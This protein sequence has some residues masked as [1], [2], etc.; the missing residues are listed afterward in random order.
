M[1]KLEDLESSHLVNGWL[2][3]WE[4]E[5]G[6]YEARGDVMYDDEHDEIPEPALWR[7]AVEL[8]RIL[9]AEGYDADAQHSEKGWCEVVVNEK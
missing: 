7:A 8:E 2:F 9:I 1:K 4:R 3:T 6:M 5:N